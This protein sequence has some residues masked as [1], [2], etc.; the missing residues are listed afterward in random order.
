MFL[1]IALIYYYEVNIMLREGIDYKGRKWEERIPRKQDEDL[2]GFRREMFEV[3][4]PVYYYNLKGNKETGYLCCCGCGNEFCGIGHQLKNKT[5]GCESC[6]KSHKNDKEKE[7]MIGR[8]FGE[9]TVKSY[10]THTTSPGNRIITFYRCSCSCGKEAGA[11]EKWVLENGTKIM[12]K[13]CSSRK[14]II[15]NK[16]GNLL[17]KQFGLLKIIAGPEIQKGKARWQGKC[18]CGETVWASKHDL[19]AGRVSSCGCQKSFGERR[20]AEILNENNIKHIRQYTF[21]DC[22]SSKGRKMLFDFAIFNEKDELQFLIEYDGSQ[23]FFASGS[24]WNTKE[25]HLA[26]RE[27]DELKNQYCKE[28]NILLKRIPYMEKSNLSLELLFDNKYFI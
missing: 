12:C 16:R 26:L 22:I 15:E 28:H 4:F 6:S 1:P 3:L 23:H 10:F 7:A 13:S 19:E 18:T 25:K 17:G 8:K 21:E 11:Y 20:I 14:Y 2:S 24:G 27:R 5:K 9:L